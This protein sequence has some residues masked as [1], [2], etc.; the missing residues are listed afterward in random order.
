[1]SSVTRTISLRP[2]ACRETKTGTGV[3]LHTILEEV[4]ADAELCATEALT[5]ITHEN[6]EKISEYDGLKPAVAGRGMGIRFSVPGRGTGRSRFEWMV[7]EYAVSQLRAWR[8]RHKASTG[9]TDQYVST[10]FKRTANPNK[11]DFLKPRLA[12]SV[13]DKQYHTVKIK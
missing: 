1:M 4:R 13:T 7:R 8:E 2:F 3:D 5:H 11:P 10:G 9:Q 12:L 6:L